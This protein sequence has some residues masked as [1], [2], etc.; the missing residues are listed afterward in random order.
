MVLHD[1]RTANTYTVLDHLCPICETYGCG[2]SLYDQYDELH[3][4]YMLVLAERDR[5]FYELHYREMQIHNS[6]YI[7]DQ[8][9][10][11]Q[12]SVMESRAQFIRNEINRQL[13]FE[14]MIK[15]KKF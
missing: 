9:R 4:K 10:H 13:V 8:S 12:D 11:S 6:G 7:I 15:E 3:R 1:L 2:H 14:K 5:L